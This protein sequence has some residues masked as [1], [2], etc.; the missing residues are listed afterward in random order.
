MWDKG[1]AHSHTVPNIFDR[2]NNGVVV[3]VVILYNVS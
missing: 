1:E 3:V 2:R